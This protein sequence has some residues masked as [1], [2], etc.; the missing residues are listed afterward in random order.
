MLRK[1]IESL[2]AAPARS[3]VLNT[4]DQSVNKNDKRPEV[5][6]VPS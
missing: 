1:E 6:T 2:L 4:S 5:S 3:G